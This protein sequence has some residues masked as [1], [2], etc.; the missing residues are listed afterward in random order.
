MTN[1]RSFPHGLPGPTGP[2]GGGGVCPDPRM[3]SAYLDGKLDAAQRGPIEDHISRCEDCYFVVRETA[4]TWAEMD[5]G[6]EVRGPVT[7]GAPES[8]P[9]VVRARPPYLSTYLLPLAATLIV[10]AGALLFW[11]QT[12]GGGD[13]PRAGLVAAV[14]ERRFFD[15]RLTGGFKYGERIGPTRG[16][17]PG[18]LPGTAGDWEVLAAAARIKKEIAAPQTPQDRAT[19]AS[20]HLVLGEADAAVLLLERAVRDSPGSEEGR[21]RLLSDLSA[22]Y[23]TRAASEGRADD[24]PRA[25]ERAVQAV[26]VDP[27]LRE[28]LFN[29]ALALEFLQLPEEAVRAWNDFLSRE[30]DPGWARE[31]TRRRDALANRPRPDF[32][33][34]SRDIHGALLSGTS[35]ELAAVVEANVGIARDVFELDLLPEVGRRADEARRLAE[36]LRRV[37]GDAYA[38]AIM[39]LAAPAKLQVRAA[40]YAR[41]RKLYDAQERGQARGPFEE[42]V[43]LGAPADVLSLWARQHLAVLTL[44]TDPRE[45]LRLCQDLLGAARRQSFRILS[46]RVLWIRGIALDT[47]RDTAGAIESFREA[48]AL[49]T[50]AK[51]FDH[52]GFMNVQLAEPYWT[53]GQAPESWRAR[54]FGLAQSDLLR[55]RSRAYV[56]VLAATDAAR[57]MGLPRAARH[58]AAEAATEIEATGSG[59]TGALAL[60]FKRALVSAELSPSRGLDELLATQDRIRSLDDAA[61]RDWHQAEFDLLAGQ[62]SVPEAGP[63]ASRQRVTL[64]LDRAREKEMDYAVPRLRLNLGRWDL[65]EGRTEAAL[66]NFEES[67]AE[68]ERTRAATDELRRA[69]AAAAIDALRAAVEPL[70]ARPEFPARRSLILAERLNALRFG[71]PERLTVSDLP[72]ALRRLPERAAVLVLLT[73]RNTVAVWSISSSGLEL[74]VIPDKQGLLARLEDLAA[75]TPSGV[76]TSEAGRRVSGLLLAPVFKEVSTAESVEIV[77]DAEL[78]NVPFAAL[79]RPD[80][81]APWGS[82]TEIVSA[83]TLWFALSGPRLAPR[84]RRVLA[85]GAPNDPRFVSLPRA[86]VEINGIADAYGGGTRLIG[87]QATLDALRRELARATTLHLATHALLNPN[88]PD[89]SVIALAGGRDLDAEAIGR[90][91]L[92]GL[93]LV[94]LAACE[95]GRTTASPGIGS[96]DFAGAFLKAGA[97]QVLASR[98]ALPDDSPLFLEFHRLVSRGLAPRAALQRLR[99]ESPAARAL[100]TFYAPLVISGGPA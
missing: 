86:A 45:T 76:E 58:I 48:Q 54:I 16:G 77:A 32:E 88:H 70:L 99:R 6:A 17:E 67:L 12:Q 55:E 43:R 98:T 4:L 84:S 27:A 13:G 78:A 60:L 82:A 22:A 91:S 20:A 30:K 65:H 69:E 74:Q 52:A 95:T 28:A 14:G 93:D 5:G 9:P 100:L 39:D 61:T 94:T 81:G 75:E 33:K 2:A 89:S 24:Y 8:A 40:L 96:F 7:H 68:I 11:R 72:G 3:L 66:R 97:S 85:V 90:L 49:L 71:A 46:A 47:L 23:L 73:L 56:G 35:E 15:A 37:T 87:S 26:E 83:P 18:S 62:L 10:G 29:K 38:I 19:L 50:G 25:L 42:V 79:P 36:A 63:R 59:D 53:A 92:K 64:A 34:M 80:N 31:A 51:C 57:D 21:A 1:E 41:A 44:G